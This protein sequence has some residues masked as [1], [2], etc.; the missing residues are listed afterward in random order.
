MYTP[1]ILA[2]A[3]A[4]LPIYEGRV[5][6]TSSAGA[7]RPAFVYE[8]RVVIGDDG[9]IRASHLTREPGKRAIVIDET[10]HVTSAYT[11][12]RFVADNRQ[13]GYRGRVSVSV[14]GRRLDY[15]LRRDDGRVVRKSEAIDAPAVAG[16]SLHGFI[17]QHW[18]PLVSGEKVNVRMIVL[19]KTA[20]YGFRIALH[21]QG[22]G[23]T[24]FSVTPT[25]WLVRLALAPLTVAFDTRTR[26]VLRYEG[27]VPP[28]LVVNGKAREFDARVDYTMQS[29]CTADAAQTP[30]ALR[31]SCSCTAWR[32][33]APY[34]PHV[35]ILS[36]DSRTTVGYSTVGND[37]N[38]R[39]GDGPGRPLRSRRRRSSPACL[40][41][42]PL[43]VASG[44]RVCGDS[45]N[46][47]HARRWKQANARPA[48]SAT[49]TGATVHTMAGTSAGTSKARN[50]T[51]DTAIAVAIASAKT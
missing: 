29:P 34:R 49:I 11:L 4:A 39:R 21:S 7:A 44:C 38:G 13:Q 46:R 37:V 42:R 9:D 25:N 41:F 5:Y 23:R 32:F 51:Q 27:R 15:E 19:G 36:V 1:T 3:A 47:P 18:D 45:G 6:Q 24:A 33:P 16:P 12:R 40:I 35:V 48:S 20:T 8:R 28:L 43:P 17:L 22:G 26:H 10:A 30:A 2:L 14:D 50:V 31:R